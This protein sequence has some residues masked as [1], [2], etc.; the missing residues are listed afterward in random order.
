MLPYPGMFYEMALGLNLT[1]YTFVG[2]GGYE[3]TINV[4][5][6]VLDAVLSEIARDFPEL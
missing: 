4:D 1:Y 5:I 6:A 3:T 2:S